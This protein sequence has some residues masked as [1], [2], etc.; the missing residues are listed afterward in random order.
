MRLMV[1]MLGMLALLALSGCAVGQWTPEAKYLAAQEAFNSTV[2]GL[3]TLREEGA[4]TRAEASEIGNYIEAAQAMLDQW[5][6]AMNGDRPTGAYSERFRHYLKTLRR[7][8]ERAS[9]DQGT[10]AP[11]GVLPPDRQ[12]RMVRR[13]LQARR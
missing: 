13:V 9:Q 10:A 2:D 7:Y 4:F 8:L 5:H 1:A 6:A 12:R 3:A 11:G